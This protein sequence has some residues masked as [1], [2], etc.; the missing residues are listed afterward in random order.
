M[1]KSFDGLS[2]IVQNALGR[3]P[4]HGDVYIFVN[5]TRNRIKLLHLEPGGFV[6]Y[7]KRLEKGRL[8]LP[9]SNHKSQVLTWSD[10]V[11]IIEGINPI[12]VKRK[13]RF[14]PTSKSA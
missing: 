4:T 10:L 1:R 13:V 7:Y 14:L 11:L 8:S 2:G 9:P 3:Q 6:L 12:Q 5:K